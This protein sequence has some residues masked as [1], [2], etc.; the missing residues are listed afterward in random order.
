TFLIPIAQLPKGI[1]HSYKL[2]FA[3]TWRHCK[4]PSKSFATISSSTPNSS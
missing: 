4:N 1:T 2:G 3:Q